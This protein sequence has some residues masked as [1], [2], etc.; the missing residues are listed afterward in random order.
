M[1][2]FLRAFLL[3]SGVAILWSVRKSAAV[4]SLP[5][6]VRILVFVCGF[7]LVTMSGIV[8]HAH[9]TLR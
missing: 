3:V 4:R 6:G 2:S 1:D 5:V 8:G 7:A 9:P